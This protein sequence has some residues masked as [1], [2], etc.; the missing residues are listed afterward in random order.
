MTNF[1]RVGAISNSHVGKSFEDIALDF[2]IQQGLLLAPRFSVELGVGEKKGRHNFD[3]GAANPAVL[4]ECKS[5]KWT[6]T[7]NAPSA[8]LT[9]W[10]E[11]MYYFLLAPPGYRKVLFVLKHAHPK[12]GET[13]G[14]YYLR[15]YGHLVPKDVEIFEWDEPGGVVTRLH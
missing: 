1:Q 8:K 15:R 2:F 13:L 5:H 14:E 10:N 4:V 3:F 9:V 6:E 7:G 11:A 12:H